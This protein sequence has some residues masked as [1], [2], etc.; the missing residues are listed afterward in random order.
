MCRLQIDLLAA[1]QSSL[2]A[3]IKLDGLAMCKSQPHEF[4][5]AVGLSAAALFV[6]DQILRED[7]VLRTSFSGRY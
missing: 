1:E 2:F 6:I 7:D 5:P 4:A 3:P